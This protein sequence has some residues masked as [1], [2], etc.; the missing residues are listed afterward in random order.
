MLQ[1]LPQRDIQLANKFLNDR[2]FKSLLEI[3]DSDIYLV[4]KNL[5]KEVPDEEYVDID[6]DSLLQLR[7]D[8][9][10]YMS[11]LVLPEEDDLG[12]QFF[13]DYE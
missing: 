9:S 5:A 13:E 6:L 4:R 3:V 12:Y 11:Y 2:S 8:I 7:S 10:E 1:C